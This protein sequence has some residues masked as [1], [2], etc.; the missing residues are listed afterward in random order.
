VPATAAVDVPEGGSV[1][2]AVSAALPGGAWGTI[3]DLELVRALPEGADTTALRGLVERAEGIDRDLYTSDSLARL[4]VAVEI[5]H[6]VLS[7]LASEDT[8]V[9]EA[10]TL[11]ETAVDGLV[12]TDDAVEP[13]A[14]ARLSQVNAPG[15]DRRDGDYVV[16]MS[17]PHG[18]NGTSLRVYE[19]GDLLATLPL[20]YAGDEA[21]TADLEIAGRA[22][23][24]YV[25]TGE[26]I[27]S[28]G[29]TAVN[30]LMVRV[31]P[32]PSG[33]APRGR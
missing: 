16:R 5:A 30:P 12:T 3:D 24:R 15:A 21:Q 28:Q 26:L 13:P 33:N 18:V 2:V 25:Y 31:D 4:D 1:T 27:N 22:A 14:R 7:A 11:L 29:A 19:N 8:T 6:V 17:L 32:R 10:T 9:D 23:G 20:T